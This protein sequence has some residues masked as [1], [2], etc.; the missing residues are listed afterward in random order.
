MDPIDAREAVVLKLVLVLVVEPREK[1]R[2]S[3]RTTKRARCS[4]H[5][6]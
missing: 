1:P 5:V 2:M 3:M 4:R 6:L